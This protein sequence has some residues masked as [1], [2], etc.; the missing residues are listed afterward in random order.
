VQPTEIN[1]P[2]EF[3][4]MLSALGLA[5]TRIAELF[6]V[7]SRS[8]RRWQHGERRVPRGVD[9]VFRLMAAGVVTIAEVEEAA[10][11]ALPPHGPTVVPNLSRALPSSSSRCRAQKQPPSPKRSSRSLL[12]PADGRVVTHEILVS[13]FAAIRSFEGPIVTVIM[14]WPT[15]WFSFYLRDKTTFNNLMA[16]QSALQQDEHS[17]RTIGADDVFRFAQAFCCDGRGIA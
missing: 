13:I 3:H 9:I 15:W 7:G 6:G 8:V 2:I 14:L 5:Q 1:A 12:G 4:A 17:I 16:F 11:P 10:A